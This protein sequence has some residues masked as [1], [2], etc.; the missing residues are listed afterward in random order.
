MRKQKGAT[1]ITWVAG[2][3]AVIFV[4]IT[5][6]KLAPVYLEF[7]TVRSLIDKV[8]EDGTIA[9]ASTQQVRRKVGDYIDINGLYG[10]TPNDFSV[11]DVDGKN[12]VRALEVSY[13]VRKH[14]FANI[15]FLMIFEYSK[16]LGAAGDT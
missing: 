11:V 7:Y 8:A 1:F 12:S 15:D 5:G 14:W 13:E 2:A 16:E 9:R 3:G 4:F 6:V 10:I